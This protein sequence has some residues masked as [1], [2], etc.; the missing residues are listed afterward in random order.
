MVKLKKKETDRLR[1]EKVVFLFPI[2]C[3]VCL[4]FDYIIL[5]K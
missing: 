1:F 3:L 5:D 2:M 4:Y